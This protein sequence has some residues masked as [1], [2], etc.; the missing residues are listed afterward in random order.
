MSTNS[1]ILLITCTKCTRSKPQSDFYT[2]LRGKN[3]RTSRCKD[4]LNTASK[5]RWRNLTTEQ[6]QEQF[7]KNRVNGRRHR[8]KRLY[9]ISLDEHDAMLQ[10]QGGGCAVCG[11]QPDDDKYLCV[12]H[13]HDTGRVRGLLCQPCNASLGLLREDVTRINMLAA[14]VKDNCNVY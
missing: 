3:G 12:D 4:C 7:R 14:Y 6:K 2:D 1:E 9:G 11:Y 5:K 10:A 8:L 13:C